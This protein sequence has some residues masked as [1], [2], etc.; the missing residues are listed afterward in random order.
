[1]S[2]PYL[3][4]AADSQSCGDFERVRS[5]HSKTKQKDNNEGSCFWISLGEA[6]CQDSSI[7]AVQQRHAPPAHLHGPNLQRWGK[8]RDVKVL[9]I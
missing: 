5:I 9:V 4:K 3:R 7:L 8:G 6:Y 1:M 2:A